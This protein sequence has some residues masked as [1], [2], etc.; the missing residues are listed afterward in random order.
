MAPAALSVAPPVEARHLRLVLAI[1]DEGGLTRAARRLHLSQSA[2]S[3]QLK[4]VEEALGVA[5]FLRH[6]RKMVLTDAGQRLLERARPIVADL[7]ALGDELREHAAGTRG[8]L[9]IA[10]ECYTCYEWLPPVLHGFHRRHP[11]VDVSIV[12]EATSDPIAA[13]VEGQIDLAIV[14]RVPESARRSRSGPV[15]R[16]TAP[17][18]PR[19]SPACGA[20]R[21]AAG[22]PRERASPAL[23]AAENFFY[24]DFFA[25]AAHPASVDVVRLTE[26]ILSMV[27]AGLGVTVAAAW[28]VGPELAAGRLVG[29]RL[30]ARGYRRDWKAA[31]RRP[32]HA[33]RPAHVDDFVKLVAANVVPA[34]FAARGSTRRRKASS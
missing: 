12:A 6:K 20:S 9:R 22:G 2:L 10:T 34:R 14:T 33:T 31:I 30:G 15:P 26:A 18:R 17:G 21:R 16:R 25:R 13:L 19:G 24:R 4:Q 27:R 23:H 1:V 28:A 7:D 8:R 3:H 29:V 5:L 32:P 11:G